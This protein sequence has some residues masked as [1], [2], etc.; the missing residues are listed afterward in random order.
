MY[1]KEIAMVKLNVEKK[2]SFLMNNDKK[3]CIYCNKFW[4][5]LMKQKK[6]KKYKEEKNV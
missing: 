5:E 4:Y 2:I 1:F 6:K 3:K